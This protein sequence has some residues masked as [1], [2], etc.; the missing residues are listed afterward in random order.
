MPRF[1]SIGPLDF[2]TEG[3]LLLSNDG[4]LSRHLVLAS[5]GWLRGNRLRVWGDITQADLDK[6]KNGITV[7]GLRYG[8]IEATLDKIQAS[9]AWLTIG[10]REGKNREVRKVL[11]QLGLE[12]NRLIRISYGPFQLSDLKPGEVEPVRRRILVD[13]LGP[14]LASEFGLGK[15]SEP[16]DVRRG[17]KP[18][19]PRN[20]D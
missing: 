16:N 18:K 7:D 20:D 9:N 2:N 3:L 10:L 14:R 5:T 1:V 11:S 13:Q 4:A 8:P 17:R 19:R 6:L 12:V 15:D